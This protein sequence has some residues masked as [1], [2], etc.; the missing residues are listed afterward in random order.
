MNRPCYTDDALRIHL[1]QYEPSLKGLIGSTDDVNVRLQQ[2]NRGESSYS[3][4]YAPW[5]IET[6]TA[7]Q[8]RGDSDQL[9]LGGRLV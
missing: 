2:H 1:R 3:K 4:R 7:R 8:A 5:R 6:Y 9:H